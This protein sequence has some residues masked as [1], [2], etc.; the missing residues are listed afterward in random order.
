M[1]I[2]AL[3]FALS[4]FVIVRSN[5]LNS[6]ILFLIMCML[7]WA[8]VEFYIGFSRSIDGI[9]PDH[10]IIKASR[11]FWSLFALYSWFDLRNDW[12][13]IEIPERFLVILLIVYVA[14][15]LIRAWAVIHLGKSFSY[16]VKPPDGN[17]LITTGPYRFVRH[18]GYLG[19]IIL[20]TLPGIIVGSVAGFAGLVITTITQTSIRIREED[21]MLEKE[22]G[23]AFLTYKRKTHRLLPYLY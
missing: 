7:A 8:A 13:T 4:G 20:A 16:A 10:S 6:F 15:L 23:A 12:T 18:P 22:F 9:A 11:M 19:L 21:R 14:G 3:I 17:V 1:G 2:S 5:H